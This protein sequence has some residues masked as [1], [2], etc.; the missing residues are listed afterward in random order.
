QLLRRAVLEGYL[1]GRHEP[2]VHPLVP[3]VA[4]VMRRPYP[5]LTQTLER[6]GFVV[7]AEEEYFLRTVDKGLKKLE[8]AIEALRAEGKCTISGDD[9]F[10]LHQTDGFLIELTE[11]I[12][13]RNN[14][15][16]NRGR[17]RE[18]MEEH[19]RISGSKAFADSVM[20]AGP[21]D[22]LR[23]TCAGTEF[24]GYEPTQADGE[25]VGTAA[26]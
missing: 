12:A 23:E 2:V 1:L 20:Q 15:S 7:K 4:R 3:T 24:L 11:A 9:A 22:A 25:V 6:V 16:V 5:E 18:L 10:D 8:R 14:L 26:R 21:I 13:A 19:H 17:F